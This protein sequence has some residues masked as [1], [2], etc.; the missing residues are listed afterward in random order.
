MTK[1]AAKREIDS[2][3]FYLQNHT[4]DY[5]E[6]GHTAMMMAAKAL[7]V[8][9]AVIDRVLEIIDKHIDFT[10]DCHDDISPLMGLRMDI[11]QMKGGDEE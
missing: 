10:R 1:E 5:G 8:E 11:E 4:D 7:E 2:L 9:N 3:D 6:S